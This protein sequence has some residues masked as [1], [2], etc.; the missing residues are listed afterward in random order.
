MAATKFTYEVEHNGKISLLD[1]LLMR[2]N[3]KLETTVFSKETN[4]DVYLHW[5]S[6]APIT[7]K[8]GTLRTLDR[9]A[10][11]VH[12]NDNLLQEELHYIEMYFTEINGYPKWL[13][14]QTLHSFKTSNKTITTRLITKT[15]TIQI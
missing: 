6:F 11:T 9:Q 4:N 2:I 7:W 14:K 1:D 5:R 10:Y 13:L 8:K 12:L 15:T 3:E